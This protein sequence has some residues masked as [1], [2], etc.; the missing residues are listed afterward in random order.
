MVENELERVVDRAEEF[1]SKAGTY[2]IQL[3]GDR[4]KL[5]ELEDLAAKNGEQEDKL[6]EEVRKLSEDHING[7]T[8]AE[9]A[10]KTVEKLEATIDGHLENL[11]EEKNSFIELSKALDQCLNDM[12]TVA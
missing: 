4:N 9:F 7:E 6:E 11:Q 2:E 12:M 10:E 3:E 5:R 1:E 8:R